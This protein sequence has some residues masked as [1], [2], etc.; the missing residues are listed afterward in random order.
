MTTDDTTTDVDT[1]D[2]LNT[3]FL[4]DISLNKL[5]ELQAELILQSII[6][7]KRDH[8]IKCYMALIQH[9]YREINYVGFVF[10][11]ILSSDADAER[12]KGNFRLRVFV[13]SPVNPESDPPTSM[14]VANEL[15]FDIERFRKLDS[16]QLLNAILEIE[17][18]AHKWAHSL[19]NLSEN[20]ERILTISTREQREHYEQLRNSDTD[21]TH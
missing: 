14:L 8:S 19:A 1:D 15:T 18:D 10:M 2:E 16:K 11:P 4:E 7:A 6:G 17:Y 9:C 20:P 21:V 5:T 3:S 13:D 12:V